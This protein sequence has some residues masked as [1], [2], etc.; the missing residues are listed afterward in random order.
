M[1][2]KKNK[3]SLAMLLKNKFL[4]FI[5][6]N[7][8]LIG[9]STNSGYLKDRGKDFSDIFEASIGYGGGLEAIVYTGQYS[10]GFSMGPFFSFEL[11]R[12]NV[13]VSETANFAFRPMFKNLTKETSKNFSNASEDFFRKRMLD[14]FNNE[15][16]DSSN[17]TIRTISPYTNNPKSL[18]SRIGF[19]ISF[20]VIS[21]SFA[22]YTGEIADFFLG[23]FGADIYNDDYHKNVDKMKEEL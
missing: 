5:A 1:I 17:K 4:F 20:I 2:C 22:I 23:W 12:G 3:K 21:C 10:N 19:K 6:I 8:F 13:S 18:N 14:E 16:R 15:A 9:C 11:N 7:L